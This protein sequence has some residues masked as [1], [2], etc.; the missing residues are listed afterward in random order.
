[1][2]HIIQY[3]FDCWVEPDAHL[4]LAKSASPLAI[5]AR[6]LNSEELQYFSNKKIIPR[7][8]K[9]A[10]DAVVFIAHKDIQTTGIRKIRE[11]ETVRKV[12]A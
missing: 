1:M 8:T 6:N 5:L 3:M 10:E 11:K 2:Q 4:F 7:I 12:N 9:F